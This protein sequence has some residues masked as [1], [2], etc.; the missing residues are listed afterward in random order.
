MDEFKVFR[1]AL[2]R[3]FERMSERSLF[4]TDVSKDELWD[5]YLDSFPEGTN[6]IFRERREY[7]CNAC[8]SFIRAC[9]SVVTVVNNRLE[10]IWDLVNLEDH[11]QVVANAMSKLVKSKK[12]K[13][14]FVSSEKRIG[15]DFTQQIH[16]VPPITFGI[17]NHFYVDVGKRNIMSNDLIL[18]HLSHKRSG[19]HLFRRA[20]EEISI[21][22]IEIVMDLINQNSVY[23]GEE[24][25]TSVKKFHA[26][27]LGYRSI[28]DEN[29]R[30]NFCWNA[31]EVDSV[32]RIK[33]TAIGT[34]LVDISD[35]M[36]LDGAVRLFETKV[37]PANYKRPKSIITKRML[38]D[39]K[40]QVDELGFN[41]S[42]GRRYAV[43][44]D[45][46]INNVLFA[47]RSIK[48]IMNV[49]DE[50]SADL[51]VDLKKFKKLEEID[52][53]TFISDIVPKADSLELMFENR[54]VG[55]LVS[56]IA[57][58]NADAKLIFKWDNNFS[59]S[60]KGEVADS[61]KQRVKSAGGNVDGVLR[62]SIQW[63]DGDNNQNDFDA[64]CIEPN[65][66]HIWFRNKGR[67]QPSTGRLDVDIISPGNM[68]AVENITWT[69]K[70]RMQEGA[71]RFFVHNYSHV[72][73]KTGFTAE[74]EYEGQI[75]SYAYNQ[76]LNQDQK[77]TVA[78]VRFSRENGI[79]FMQSLPSTSASKYIWRVKTQT[80]NPVS[81][82][83]E[84]PNHWDEKVTGNKHYFF[85]LKNCLNPEK[86]RGFFNEFL[87]E[88]LSKYRKVFEVLGSKMLTDKSDNQ[89]SGL[90]FSST[91]RND[92]IC[93]VSGSFSRIIKIT[94]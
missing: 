80:L 28:N 32:L 86:T 89:L 49:F 59:W 77:V 75:Y 44:D 47:D 19:V 11:F 22:A 9:G 57:P 67:E 20:L 83:M 31:K 70:N 5:T 93:K 51:P 16:G 82:I 13:D 63:N 68:V 71:Y 43:V 50:I 15:K 60:Y 29:E 27:K 55:N 36:D 78:I 3:S 23:R 91:Q 38:D 90:G 17:W 53:K 76:E 79:E 73:G 2:Y 54:H 65:G 45:I 81:M 56:L 24:H 30:L 7:D 35:G 74:I 18:T 69:N 26:L 42:L 14:V 10:S 12:I 34:L 4:V 37:A 8:K 72:G 33:N 66:N 64:H 58:I 87:K 41:D 6:E 1:Q 52:I 21:E 84:S 62:F 85:M 46:T 61:M 88:D 39:A 40:K 94:F 48:K 25:K 92:I